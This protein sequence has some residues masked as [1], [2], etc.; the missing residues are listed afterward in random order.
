[1]VTPPVTDLLM[2]VGKGHMSQSCNSQ[3]AGQQ[4]KQS[5]S[6]LIITLP[7]VAMPPATKV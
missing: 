3:L 5:I 4:L 1:V 2:Q 6:C 7:S